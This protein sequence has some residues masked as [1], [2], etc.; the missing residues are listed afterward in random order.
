MSRL[1]RKSPYSRS[2]L[3]AGPVKKGDDRFQVAG[4]PRLGPGELGGVTHTRS[5]CNMELPLGVE[6]VE[7][8]PWGNTLVIHFQAPQ[9]AAPS[10][11]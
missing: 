4:N 11:R 5:A 10:P 2:T 3:H 9:F 6:R 7:G 8:R 1:S